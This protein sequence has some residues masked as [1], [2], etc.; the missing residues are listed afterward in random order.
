MKK[1]IALILVLL[2][3]LSVAMTGCGGGT[4]DPAAGSE[5]PSI[6]K[7][8]L[9]AKYNECSTVFNEVE[10]AFVENGIY[11]AEADVKAGMDAIYDLLGAAEVVVQSDDITDEERIAVNEELQTYIDQMNGFKDTYL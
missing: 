5:A 7:Q 11:D 6:S 3:M 1:S 10:G 9:I 8:D 2:L 4:E